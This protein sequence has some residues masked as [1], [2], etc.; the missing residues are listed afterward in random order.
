MKVRLALAMLLSAATFLL[1]GLTAGG[2][3]SPQAVSAAPGPWLD[4]F[5]FYR[6]ATGLSPV[7]EQA[8]L[9]SDAAKHVNYML[10]N[11]GEF[12]HS[13]NPALPGYTTE[14][15]RSARE[16][17]LFRS[18]PGFTEVQAIDGWM[19]SLFHRYG[20]LRPELQF[21]GFAIGCNAQGCAAALDVIAGLQ[22]GN[23]TPESV[24][25]PGNGQDGVATK[26]ISWQF[27]PFDAQVTLTNATLRDE[28]GQSIPF[29]TVPAQGYYNVV[30]IKPGN[31]PNNPMT[32][33][34]GTYTVE[35]TV[36]QNG[37]PITRTWTFTVGT[38]TPRC[39]G[40][41]DVA[42][43]NVA[44]PAII[45][46]TGAGIINGYATTPPRFGPFD[47]VQRAQI[48]AFLVRALLWQNE[49][50]GPRSF[51][52]FGALVVE[53]RTDSLILAN[54]CDGS[55]LCTARGYEA[56]GCSSR[57]LAFPCFGPNDGVTYAQV[58]S[59][60]A[61][62]FQF[63]SD[64]AWVPQPNGAMPYSGVPTV[65]RPDV[66]TYHAYAGTIPAAPT[67][68]AAWNAPAPRAWVA[69]VLFQA[70]QSPH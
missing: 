1:A 48:A 58:I 22:Q 66:R 9:S 13:E 2:A 38:A 59:F 5:N 21:T 44:C 8:S 33:A 4:R 35:M 56:S 64:Y 45:S 20:M 11:P 46:L 28:Q 27:R 42:A 67:S 18:S 30:A 70:L 60:V 68:E 14:G 55:G 51:T 31:D 32:L 3:V 47:G 65:H 25:Y 23:V 17:N 19:E 29:T 24:V 15:D 26:Q 36:T 54:K 62:S 52:D 69:R 39:A 53:L 40:F 7:A 34:P 57:G 37:N 12:E 6:V 63:D 16:S 50:T 10:L 41:A 61:R 49:S 43:A